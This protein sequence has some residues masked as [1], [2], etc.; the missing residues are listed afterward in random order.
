MPTR[1]DLLSMLPGSAVLL[2]ARANAAPVA[3]GPAPQLPC[4]PAQESYGVAG[5]HLH[6]V[7]NH[8]GYRPDSAKHVMLKSPPGAAVAR[9]V[10][11]F[12]KNAPPALVAPLRRTGTDFGDWLTAD[13]SA[14][15]EPGIYRV[16]VPWQYFSGDPAS[17]KA[18]DKGVVDAWSANFTIGEHVLDEPIRK[19]I[20]YY[21]IQ[22]CGDS[23]HGYNTPCHVGPIERTDKQA[24]RP[25][26][27]GWHSAHDHVRPVV[28]ILQGLFGLLAVAEHR[29]D[30]DSKEDAFQEI[31][32]GNDYFLSLQDPRGY[33]YFGVYP[34]NYFDPSPDADWWQVSQYELRTEPAPRLSQYMFAAANAQIARLYRTADPA[35][36]Q[37]CLEAASR[38]FGYA[39]AQSRGD[40]QQE[41]NRYELGA[42]A[43]A[44]AQLYRA[45][46]DSQYE[47]AASQFASGLLAL[48]VDDGHWPERRG[49]NPDPAPDYLLMNARALYPAYAALGMAEVALT[50]PGNAQAGQ[51]RAALAHFVDNFATHFSAANGFGQLPYIVYRNEP[52]ADRRAWGN[53][54]YR[55]Y[56]DTRTF[57]QGP[58]NPP[59]WRIR[60]QTGNHGVV[61]GYGVA[62]AKISKVL[63][64]PVARALAQRQMDWILG[65]N[66]LNACFIY[67]FG[68]NNPVTYP[69]ND[70]VPPV[71]DIVGAALQGVVGD[72]HDRPII[73]DGYYGSGEFW[74]PQHAWTLW[75]TA[76]MAD[77]ES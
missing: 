1:R 73:M 4:S 36:A 66:P 63:Q 13:I 67:G 40:W 60:W 7:V 39:A 11:M 26:P 72:E 43:Y 30:L 24:A 18:W 74:M 70:F 33:I 3:S 29:P 2:S 53:K 55:Y 8:L 21:R 56:L 12:R 6:P 62:L 16:A 37:R 15:K 28:E 5:V 44:S 14:I 69:S 54:S 65:V 9:V 34:K 71:P 45:T 48:Q 49:R 61:A 68:R 20:D 41:L 76:A 46:A 42:A 75:L 47:L 31:R 10:H 22:S 77:H 64:S 51:W 38:C 32:W 35:Y 17:S 23:R 19:M 58:G 27:G 25:V 57:L 52:A 59:K 50:F